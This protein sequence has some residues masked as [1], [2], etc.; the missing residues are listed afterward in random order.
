MQQAEFVKGCLMNAKQKGV[1]L[2]PLTVNLPFNC[3]NM[4]FP[5]TLEEECQA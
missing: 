3:K 2:P 1:F 4:D 5:A